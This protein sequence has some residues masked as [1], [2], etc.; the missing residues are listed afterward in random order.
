MYSL[1]VVICSLIEVML[2]AVVFIAGI[3]V[4]ILLLLFGVIVDISYSMFNK[5]RRSK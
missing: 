1:L 5:E 2:C 4:F 3:A